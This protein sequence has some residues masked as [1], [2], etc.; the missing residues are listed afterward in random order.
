M[1][2]DAKLE[3]AG[4]ANFTDTQ[5]DLFAQGFSFSGYERDPVF[6][7]LGADAFDK[8]FLKISGVSGLDSVSDGRG[9]GESQ[10]TVVYTVTKQ[11]NR[12]SD[13]KCSKEYRRV[14]G[15]VL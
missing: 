8:R 1:A 13:P 5:A 14:I 6:L 4:S 9:S 10:R 11:Y 7:N 3:E 2:A 15:V 12:C